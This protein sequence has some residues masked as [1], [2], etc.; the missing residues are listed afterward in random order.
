MS[1]KAAETTRNITKAFGPGTA[2]EQTV[3]W[4]FKKFCKRDESLEDEEHSSRPS[5]VDNHQLKAIIKADPLTTIQEAAKKLSVD[6]SIVVWH[7]KLTG[8]VKK[9]DKWMPRELSENQKNHHFEVS[10]SHILCNNSEPF[11]DQTPTCNEKWIVSDNQWQPAYGWMKKHF[12]KPNLHQKKVMVTV[13]WSATLLTHYSFLNPGETITSEKYAQQINEMHQKLQHMQPALINRKGPILL[14]D[15][16]WPYI[17]QPMLQ[18][19]NELGYEVL[20]HLPYSPDLWPTDY[21]FFQDLYNFLQRRR[22][23]KQQ[24]AEY[25]FQELVKSQSMDFYA[26]GINKLIPHWQK[27]CWLNDSYFD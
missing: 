7:L 14:Q 15:N 17:V 12:P 1:N 11:L 8:K 19:L 23:H 9:L 10:S 27:M 24:E 22:F 16:I 4:W 25:V 21:H 13:W 6:H 26:T 3:Q 20:P 5:E 2:N 18:K